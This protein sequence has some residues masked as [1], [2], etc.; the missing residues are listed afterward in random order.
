MTKLRIFR[1]VCFTLLFG[2]VGLSLIYYQIAKF[3]PTVQLKNQGGQGKALVGGEFELQDQFGKKRHTKEYLGKYRL[4]YFGYSFCPD[5]C[6][7]GLQNITDGLKLL[8]RDREEVVPIFVTIDPERDTVRQLQQYASHFHPSFVMMTGTRPQVD[9]AVKA[10]RVYAVRARDDNSSTEYLMDHSTMIYL[11]DREGNFIEHFPHTVEPEDL[12][13][14]VRKY[15]LAEH[16]A[17]RA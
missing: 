9:L 4:V 1:I 6:P 15:L 14:G 13:K 16:K 2:G 10:Y 5:I 7:L 8:G 11:V 3:Q 17:K 12:A